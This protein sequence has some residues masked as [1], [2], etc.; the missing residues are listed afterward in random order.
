MTIRTSHIAIVVL[1]ATEH[2]EI[3]AAAAALV[4]IKRHRGVSLAKPH[5]ARGCY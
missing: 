5:L 4:I 2:L 3:A 1:H